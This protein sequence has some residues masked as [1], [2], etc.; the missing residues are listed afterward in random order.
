MDLAFVEGELQLEPPINALVL[1]EIHLFVVVG[2][3]HPWSNRNE[4]ELRALDGQAFVSRTTGSQTRSWTDQIFAQYGIQ[5]RTVAEFDNPESIR[6]AVA[7]GMG[8]T[9]LAEWGLGDAYSGLQLHTLSIAGLD[10]RRTLKLVWASE[11]PIK[12]IGRAFLTL[13]AD[14]YPQLSQVTS[15]QIELVRIMP[16]RESYRASSTSCGPEIGQIQGELA[17]KD[18]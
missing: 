8:F 5:P 18:S 4:I 12:P 2:T 10:L 16:G 14:Q 15:G 11:T 3:G 13:L 9:I 7:T 6:Q 17:K 1:Q